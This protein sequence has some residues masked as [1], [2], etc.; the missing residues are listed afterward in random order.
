MKVYEIRRYPDPILSRRAREVDPRDVRDGR[1]DRIVRR[2]L[3]TLRYNK[4]F[5]L[6]APQ[7]GLDIRLIIVATPS[8][9]D[10]VASFL[11]A[12]NPVMILAEGATRMREGCLS[13]PG[14][15][16]W[17]PRPGAPCRIE[18][19]GH[20]GVPFAIEVRDL[21]SRACQHEVDHLDGILIKD[22]GSPA[23]AMPAGN[24]GSPNRR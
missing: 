7:V 20:D 22:R 9:A 19:L 5:G 2:M 13:I 8:E 14:Q 21:F 18:G 12:F 6:A 10:N 23:L 16:F 4:G 24:Q 17:V 3:R 15:H 11:V 1:L